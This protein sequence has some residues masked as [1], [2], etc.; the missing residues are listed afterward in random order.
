MFHTIIRLKYWS[1][2][3]KNRP[4]HDPVNFTFP[5]GAHVAEVEIDP[6]TCIVSL[7]KYTAVDDVGN[8]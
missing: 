3:S 4:D 1:P 7:V 5:G 8:G 2:G 6:E